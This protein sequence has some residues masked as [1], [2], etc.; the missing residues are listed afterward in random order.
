MSRYPEDRSHGGRGGQRPPRDHRGSAPSNRRW[1]EQ[2]DFPMSEVERGEE[3]R[4]EFLSTFPGSNPNDPWRSA[5][6]TSPAG[7]IQS[8]STSTGGNRQQRMGYHPPNVSRSTTGLTPN[9]STELIE[10]I[11]REGV[12]VTATHDEEF[13][14][15][16]RAVIED[17]MFQLSQKRNEVTHLQRR[18]EDLRRETLLR[19]REDV[20]ELEPRP[21]KRRENRLEEVV[22]SPIES[23][24]S[25]S[26]SDLRVQTSYMRINDPP[27]LG[28]PRY[29]AP[30]MPTGPSHR[31]P[32]PR[33]GEGA[34]L[35]GRPYET[36]VKV[37]PPGQFVPEPSIT[38]PPP[39]PALQVP[40]DDDD[41]YR[42][43]ESDE[44]SDESDRP[45]KKKQP[46]PIDPQDDG[47]I[48]DFWG[49]CYPNGSPTAERDNSLR[50]MYSNR[51]YFSR[52]SNAL[53]VGQSAADASAFERDHHDAYYPPN[54]NQT[55]VRSIRGIPGSIL[56]LNKLLTL[57]KDRTNRFR[58]REAEEAFLLLRELYDISRRV[59]PAYRDR[60]MERIVRPGEF[61]PDITRYFGNGAVEPLRP[62]IS[63]PNALG[64]MGRA[65][66]QAPSLSES[67]NLDAYGLY[68][69]LHGRPGS[70]NAIAG[71][72]IDYAYRVNRRTVFGL[73]LARL[74]IPTDRDAQPTFRRLLAC[75]MALPH[76]YHEAIT[77]YNQRHLLSPFLQQGGPT[78]QLSRPRIEAHRIP[79]LG[80]E[81]VIT[82]LLDNRIP[83]SWMD[84][85]YLYGLTYLNAHYSGN[86]P[87]RALFDEIDN[88][89]LARLQLY[90]TPPPIA[91]W[92]GWRS[93]SEGDI[94]RLHA[95]V[96]AVEDKPPAPRNSGNVPEH[97]QGLEAPAWLLVGQDG[98]ITHLAHRPASAAQAY[99]TAMAAATPLG[100]L[101][102]HPPTSST[103]LTTGSGDPANAGVTSPITP[104]VSANPANA[105]VEAPMDTQE[106]GAGHGLGA[107]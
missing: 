23:I 72:L 4:S 75:L 107:D 100:T 39:R 104:I 29:R 19:K 85:S 56:E 24:P 25:S 17:L 45:T 90:G 54:S 44:S 42:F 52:R 21:P 60:A 38:L 30:V 59:L 15:E 47:Y 69:L 55:Y 70:S 20:G 11:R 50:F 103:L 58:Y 91:E 106:E 9:R 26:S 76:R 97:R 6:L 35:N 5:P 62:T 3:M 41:P 80:L 83:P 99:A 34:S 87:H 16:A 40:S 92:D 101:L 68:I 82:V 31:A 67:F 57:V 105:G 43:D 1:D 53:F 33:R 51:A 96:D 61:E 46:N 89:R 27:R 71:V 48:P 73:A 32:T 65:S 98:L 18:T 77:D 10:R 63:R 49:I 8:S 14:L 13:P 93:P 95:I 64:P 2:D 22:P 94:A 84:H 28:P 79:N 81:D 86:G 88:E 74:L 7:S 66:L 102:H 37:T 78:Y 12:T 36:A